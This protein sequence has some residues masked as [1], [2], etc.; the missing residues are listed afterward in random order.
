LNKNSFI[1]KSNVL[2]AIDCFNSVLK[3]DPFYLNAYLSKGLALKELKN[4]HEAL[5]QFNKAL[6]IDPDFIVAQNSKINLLKMINQS[7]ID[8]SEISSINESI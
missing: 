4:N 8:Q 2:K 7:K 3:I 6:E 5:E 1:G